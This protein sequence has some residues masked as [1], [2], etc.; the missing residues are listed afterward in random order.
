MIG[1]MARMPKYSTLT[2]PFLCFFFQHP[3]IRIFSSEYFYS[4]KPVFDAPEITD[5]IIRMDGF[6]PNKHDVRHV[7]CHVTGKEHMVTCLSLG[8][9]R[10][11][12]KFNPAEIA[13]IV[14]IVFF[15]IG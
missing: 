14:S 2:L 3:S 8:D 9:D 12:C 10:E 11:G 13:K 4:G 6:W 1:L 7:F 5:S 15:L